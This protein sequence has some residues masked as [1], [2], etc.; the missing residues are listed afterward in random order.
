MAD[1]MTGEVRDLVKRGVFADTCQKFGYRIGKDSK[2]HTVQIADYRN[3]RGELVGQKVRTPDKDFYVL[4]DLGSEAPLFGMHLFQDRG[5]RVMV[6]EGEIDAMSLGQ[7]FPSW[8]VVSVPKGAAG[9]KS[10][11]KH[12]LEWL[13]GFDEIVLCFDMDEPGRKAMADCATLFTPGK[14]KTW[15]IPLK[16]AS[17]MLVA[18][19]AKEMTQ[20]V[21]NARTFRPGGIVNMADSWD[22]FRN[23]LTTPG[24]PYRWAGLTRTTMGRFPR[25][26]TTWVSGTGMGKSTGV[27]WAMYD[28]LCDGETVGHI[29]LEEDVA[30]TAERFVSMHLRK[31]L[32]INPDAATE[33]E[34][35]AAFDATCGT[36]RLWTLDHFGSTD[37]EGLIGKFRYL[38]KGC[39]ATVQAL[40]HLSIVVSGMSEDSDE[41]KTIDRTMTNLRSLVEETGMELHVVS[42]LKRVGEGKS[43]EEGGRVTLGHLRGS[44]SI[45]Q[46]SD[47]V[48]AMERN[49][50]HKDPAMRQVA[51]MRVLK[52]RR[53]GRTGPA[54]WTK[55]DDVTGEMVECDEPKPKG[56]GF[57]DE[58]GTDDLPF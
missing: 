29:A 17:D 48:I 40:D 20:A 30:K 3:L 38:A 54:C 23:R 39:G 1:F 21:Y 57:Q 44:Q 18:R 12:N 41:R 56:E 16:D 15:E 49:Q 50:Q 31:R 35:R 8:P 11:L 42:H 7:T 58:T 5:K 34:I 53:T 24:R 9:A 13:E 2:G 46:L 6:T 52:D 33:A 45:A 37:D 25:T 28:A 55:Y 36:G 26:L 14:C 4:G 51:T 22:R 32:D 19:R 27:S 10:A 47:V 43:H